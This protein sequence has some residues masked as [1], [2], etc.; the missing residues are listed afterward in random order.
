MLEAVVNM[1][2]NCEIIINNLKNVLLIKSNIV[3]FLF[4]FLIND[5]LGMKLC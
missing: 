1:S 3:I 5:F 2:K 4:S